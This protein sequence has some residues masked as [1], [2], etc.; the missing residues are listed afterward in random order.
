MRA[1]GE[2][3]RWDSV[4]ACIE[5]GF[6]YIIANRG[7]TPPF[8]PD[9]Q[10]LRIQQLFVPP[11]RM[12][13]GLPF[14]GDENPDRE[15]KAVRRAIQCSLLKMRIT[16]QYVFPNV[17]ISVNKQ[18]GR[19]MKMKNCRELMFKLF[20]VFL[21]AGICSSLAVAQE[22]EGEMKSVEE[23]FG[24]GLSEEDYYKA[25][26]LLVTATKR[27]ISLRKAP[28]IATVITAD[29]IRNMGAKSLHEVMKMVPG[30]DITISQVGRYMYGVRGIRT[31]SSEKLM[32][33]IDGHR[34]NEPITG[35]AVSQLF[36]DL[37]VEKAKQIEIV[38]G[39]GSALYGANAF[40]A[41]INII[42]KDAD[43]IDG[44]EI[45]LAGG[46]FDTQNVNVTGGKNFE[47]DGFRF[48]TNV[49]YFKT[50]G[51]GVT[52][53]SD[54]I[55]GSG[56]ADQSLEK[57]D[58]FLKMSYGDLTFKGQ[59]TRRDGGVYIGFA[60]TLTDD[61]IFR[62]TGYWGDLSYSRTLTDNFAITARG[63]FDHYEQEA[64]LEIF[65]EG[66]PGY[67]DGMI[68]SPNAKDRTLGTELQ[69][70][71]DLSDSNH[72]IFGA[73]YEHIKQ[74]DV[75]HITNFDPWTFAPIGPVQDVSSWGNWNKDVTREIWAV[76]IQDEWWVDDNLGLTA[77]VRY[78]NYDDFG[79]TVN[80]RAGLVWTVVEDLDLKFLYGQAFRAPN[81][82]ELYND[83][84]P[85]AM[86][87]TDLDAET[88][89]TYEFNVGYTF[90]K[91]HS[92][93][94]NYFYNDI[95]N[96][97]ILD[98]SQS[99]A[100]YMNKGGAEVHGIE[101]TITGRYSADNYW[102]LTYT[103]QNPEDSET[104]ED[105][106]DMPTHKATFSVNY[107]FSKHLNAHADLLWTGERPRTSGDTRDDTPSYTTVDVSLIAKNF[108]EGLEMQWTVCNL[109]DEE[110]EDPDMSGA[111]QFVRY[112]HP[113]A[114]FSAIMDVRFRF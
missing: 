36:M 1:D 112:D 75:T 34:L 20:L 102:Q 18:I 56:E 85:S 8:D 6:R 5:I 70:D 87:N 77:G 40:V 57:T 89:K 28:A 111:A 104:G 16:T 32:V 97:I 80:P 38:R 47:E 98:S 10:K 66:F 61:N 4:Q 103:W 22:T 30:F 86:G 55:G 50:D 107:G 13:E 95:E 41:V 78:D 91:F 105:L 100:R 74:Y 14:C 51:P 24:E 42:T 114:G 63:F 35:S 19:R 69:F 72:L 108:Y 82:T 62:H 59:F 39:P 81:M 106:A 67:P 25:D 99:P 44:A 76:Y 88:I 71:L 7:C 3:M 48:Y 12:G 54:M 15:N 29:E 92:I 43:D 49:D 83:A 11:R 93:N 23:M 45:N 9:K 64:Y 31:V 113:R 46:S 68:G 96:L 79:E 53:E 58:A 109:F 52:I 26:R 37:S 21:V 27:K 110:Y 90:K 84:N 73:C 33:M 2:F 65:P 94:V 101:S 17:C 60:N